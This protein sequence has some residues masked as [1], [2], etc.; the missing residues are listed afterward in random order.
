VTRARRATGTRP[1]R[2]RAPGR[3]GPPAGI[4]PEITGRPGLTI[5][6]S[7]WRWR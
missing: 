2:R 3:P 1:R 4:P 6:P 7:R 5:P